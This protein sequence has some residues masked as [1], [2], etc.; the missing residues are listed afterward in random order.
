MKS[1][2]FLLLIL[3]IFSFSLQFLVG[4]FPDT[5]SLKAAFNI[6][7]VGV[8]ISL[9]ILPWSYGSIQ[10]V[11]INKVNYVLFFEK[12]LNVVL[13]FNLLINVLILTIVLIFIPDIA[14]FKAEESFH[15]LY[16]NIP[17]FANVFRY[18]YVSQNLG[19]L[20]IPFFFYH[21]SSKKY[22]K[23]I[24]SLVLS[25]SS[26]I[27]GF[28]FYSRAQILTYILILIAYY[29]LIM[30]SL[31]QELQ[32]KVWKFIKISI[33]LI[34]AIFLVITV[35][36]F[37]AMSYYADRIP[38]NSIIKD[39]VFY[40][41][42]DYSSQGYPNGLELLDD[43]TPDRNLKGQDIFRTVN[44]FLG[45]FGLISWDSDETN[46]K[47]AKAYDYDGGAFRGYTCQMVYNFGYTIT[48]LISFA[49]YI[50][51]KKKLFNKCS[52]SIETLCIL[53]VL[54]ILPLVS[55]FYCGFALMFFPIIFIVAVKCFYILQCAIRKSLLAD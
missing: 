20:S 24:K 45:F 2:Y 50:Y 8:N 13:F 51:V 55:I 37:T 42:V 14:S 17:Y 19:V 3:Q 41:L 22:S 1:C 53:A 34:A 52:I 11:F 26:L 4:Y 35:V 7:F 10:S 39:P 48:I 28:A 44:Q 21:L 47:I 9:T 32:N 30:R 46:E 5:Y 18:A 6:F 27:S 33:Y 15:D 23:S 25:S 12:N 16:D 49:F 29:L 43:Y 54:L 36:R 38:P 31:S 40:S